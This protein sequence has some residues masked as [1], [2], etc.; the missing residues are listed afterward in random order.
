MLPD[1]MTITPASPGDLA[2]AL[3]LLGEAALPTAGVADHFAHFLVAR[4]GDSLV[5][6]AGL[7]VYRDAALLRSVAVAADWRNRGLGQALTQAAL[8]RARSRGGHMAYL[9]TTDAADFFGRKFGFVPLPRDAVDPRL[10]ASAELQGACP[11]T[12]MAM[13]RPLAEPHV[14]SLKERVRWALA[15]RTRQADA[16]PQLTPSAVLLLLYEKGGAPYVLFTR[17]TSLVED[18]KGEVSFPGGAWHPGEDPSLLATALRESHEEVGV[19]PDNVEVLGELDDTVPLSKYVITP[20]V[21]TLRSPQDFRP[22]AIE[23][24]EVLEVPLAYLKDPA[25]RRDAAREPRRYAG[26][27]ISGEY[28][29][30]GESVIWG[31]TYRI[32]R[33]FLD[34]LARD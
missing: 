21:G 4:R 28:V 23:V 26:K 32:L 22:A 7:E 30:Y 2:A 20:Y 29:V 11:D 14:L 8:D 13:V 10:G 9:L 16:Q 3:A 5:G 6:T 17:R 15:G 27:Q 24:A 18:H 12:A 34:L 1:D 19:A 33:Q 31:A 25:H